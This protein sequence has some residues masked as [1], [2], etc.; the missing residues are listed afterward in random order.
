MEIN[1]SFW[2]L[3]MQY[4]LQSIC[5]DV[6]GSV[7]NGYQVP[8]TLPTDTTGNK[9]YNDNSR[10]INAILNGLPDYEHVKVMYYKSTKE[11]W[12]KL[13][14]I[15]QGDDNIKQ[16]KLQTHRCQFESMKIMEEEENI[17]AYLLQVDEV[18]N[19]IRGLGEKIEESV[20]VKKVF[21]SLALRFDAKVYVLEDTKDLHSLTMDELQKNL[22]TYE[23]RTVNENTSRKKETFK[24][25][26]GTKNKNINLMMMN[27]M[28]K[29]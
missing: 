11:A 9:L 22:T 18:V 7:I 24:A 5:F 25:S 15:Y 3:R 23:M 20:V 27:Q 1:Y 2:S 19:T 13:Q 16:A 17:A 29:T 26:K 10:A 12:D 21:R 4:H 6:W 8:T 28:K 14:K